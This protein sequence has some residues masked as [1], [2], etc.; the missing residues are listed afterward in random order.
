MGGEGKLSEFTDFRHTVYKRTD[1]SYILKTPKGRQFMHEVN[2]KFR[3]MPFTLRS[4]ED[5]GAA[6]IGIAEAKR[7]EILQEFPVMREKRGETIAQFKFTV[8]S[9]P[10]GVKKVTGINMEDETLKGLQE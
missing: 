10:N 6:R 3:Y 7:H 9:L 4:I 8:L 5:E 1:E 2:Q